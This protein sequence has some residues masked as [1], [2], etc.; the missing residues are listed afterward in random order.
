MCSEL[1]FSLEKVYLEYI[2]SPIEK[3]RTSGKRLTEI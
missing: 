3:K 1:T 2:F